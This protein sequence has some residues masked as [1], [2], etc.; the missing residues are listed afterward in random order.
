MPPN[1][2][3]PPIPENEQQKTTIIIA[4]VLELLAEILKQEW[5]LEKD[6]TSEELMNKINGVLSDEAFN[7]LNLENRLWLSNKNRIK[8][9]K[10]KKSSIVILDGKKYEIP[11]PTLDIIKKL[12]DKWFRSTRWIAYLPSNSHFIKD[13]DDLPEQEIIK[14]QQSKHY[15]KV[16]KE[17]NTAIIIVDGQHY[18]ISRRSFFVL[19]ELYNKAINSKSGMVYADKNGHYFTLS[20]EDSN[21]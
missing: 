15:C 4:W 19:S 17:K 8:I 2:D 16:D 11:L 10:E 12:F 5:V 3:K 14:T 9:D 21:T 6:V 7:I 13:A 20:P 18:E 1:L